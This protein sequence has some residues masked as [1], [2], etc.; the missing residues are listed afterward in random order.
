MPRNKSAKL[1]A[2]AFFHAILLSPSRKPARF[3]KMFKKIRGA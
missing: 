2:V 1:N 3:R